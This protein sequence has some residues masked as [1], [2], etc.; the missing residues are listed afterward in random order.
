[1]FF[2]KRKVRSSGRTSG[3]IEITLPPEMHALEGIECRL[4]LCDGARPEMFR[5]LRLS[6]RIS[7]SNYMSP[8]HR[9]ATLATSLYRIL[10]FPF[11]RHATGM[12]AHRSPIATA[13]RSTVRSKASFKWITAA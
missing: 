6:L 11:C 1:M 12:I 5:W 10:M 8:L 7:G 3:S 9:L 13:W 4:I 2:V